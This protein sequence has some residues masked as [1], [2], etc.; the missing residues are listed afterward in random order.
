MTYDPKRSLPPLPPPCE[1]NMDELV[2]GG[3]S[4]YG[5]RFYMRD[6]DEE[7]RPEYGVYLDRA[8]AEGDTIGTLIPWKDF[9]LPYPPARAVHRLCVETVERAKRQ[10][11]EVACLGGHGRTGTFLACCAVAVGMTPDEAITLVR[12]DYCW[13]AVETN[14]QEWYVEVI[15]AIHHN[16]PVSLPP[17]EPVWKPLPK[18]E[19]SWNHPS[20]LGEMPRCR[21]CKTS[22]LHTYAVTCD[23]CG[24]PIE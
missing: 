21:D 23:I 12:K 19:V 11:I 7:P 5:S 6:D 14:R 1:H 18:K 22:P 24:G 2:L 20:L 15:H 16:L 4:L 10:K 9:G 13:K 8:W 17:P 3:I